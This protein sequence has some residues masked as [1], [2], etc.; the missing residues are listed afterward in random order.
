MNLDEISNLK[1]KMQALIFSIEDGIV[2][3]DFDGNIL[4]INDMA[5]KMLGSKAHVHKIK[6]VKKTPGRK[7]GAGKKR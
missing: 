3:T 1:T 2:M 7:K 4:V 6:I 5:K